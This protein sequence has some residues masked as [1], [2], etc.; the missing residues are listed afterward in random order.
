MKCIIRITGKVGIERD[1]EETL[2][3]LNLRTKYSCIVLNPNKVQ[4]G[5]IKRIENFVAFGDIDTQDL[6]KILE[7]RGKRV[8]NKKIDAKKIADSVEKGESL[9]KQG[10]VPFF[11]LSPPRG[12]LRSA[13]LH[14]PK[15]VLGNHKKNIIKLIERML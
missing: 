14:Y 6:E 1:V 8:D 10:L 9:K 5:M 12:G 11:R 3:R 13:R 15:G 4:E 7:E 2:Q